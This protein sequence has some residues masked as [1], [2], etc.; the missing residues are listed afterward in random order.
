MKTKQ[1]ADYLATIS[2]D[3]LP[4]DALDAAECALIDHVGVGL[5]GSRRPWTRIVAEHAISESGGDGTVPLYGRCERLR[6]GA[7]ARVNGTAS[8]SFELDDLYEH[9]SLHPGSVIIPAALGAAIDRG[10]SGRLLLEAIVVGYEA[11]GRIAVAAASQV[12][13]FHTTGTHGVFG[14]A[15]AVAR[16][17]GFD[18]DAVTNVFGVVASFAGGL[19]AFQT[20]G[21]EVKRLHPGRS[22]E[23]GLTAVA[24]SERGLTGPRDVLENKRGFFAAYG[25]ENAALDALELGPAQTYVISR[26]Y[27][28]PYASCSATH[29]VIN[30][31]RA[32][33]ATGPVD[34][35][36][37]ANVVVGSSMRGLDQNS[38]PTP[39]DTMSVQY[40]IESAVALTLLGLQGDPTAFYF[41]RYS[42]T[43]APRLASLVKVI[44]DD[45]AESVYPASMAARVTIE[46]ADGTSRTA[47]EPGLGSESDVAVRRAAIE[48]KFTALTRGLL[49]EESQQELLAAVRGL[50]SGSPIGDILEIVGPRSL[51]ASED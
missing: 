24:L 44:I 19:K 20:G 41:D 45:E 16:L 38:I 7:A 29:A 51:A 18:A 13:P 36:Q 26:T 48:D 8:H 40:S 43:D 30:A 27:Y 46:T 10:S 25:G 2:Y 9:A 12:T 47:Y 50:R 35:R 49:A 14:S 21:G 15:A 5:Y 33:Q 34:L 28:K 23:A 37:V 32:I 22:A 6:P 11:L 17:A 31:V 4:E 39:T 42:S 3:D 1:L